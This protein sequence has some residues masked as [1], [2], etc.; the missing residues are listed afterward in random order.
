MPS[1]LKKIKNARD[2]EVQQEEEFKTKQQEICTQTWYETN[3][4]SWIKQDVPFGMSKKK[5][6]PDR[7]SWINVWD[8]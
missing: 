4:M 5:D 1:S 7:N 2:A 8:N 6:K 3:S